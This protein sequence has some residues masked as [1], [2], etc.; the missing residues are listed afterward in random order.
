MFPLQASWAPDDEH[1]QASQPEPE[2]GQGQPGHPQ[3]RLCGLHS[4]LCVFYAVNRSTLSVPVISSRSYIFCQAI[5]IF[6]AVE[7][8]C[9]FLFTSLNIQQVCIYIRLQISS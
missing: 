5:K 4:S 7:H 8:S 9:L 2:G 3:H 1:E 6:V